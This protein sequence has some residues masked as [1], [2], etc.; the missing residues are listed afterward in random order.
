MTSPTK[1]A[2]V[3][4]SSSDDPM[5]STRIAALNMF[6]YLRAAGFEP[7]VV[8]EPQHGLETPDLSGLAPVIS[9]R[10]FQFVF[11]Q[12]VHG[13]SVLACVQ[14][15]REL[16]VKTV[17]SV[18]DI[19]DAE[20]ARACDITLT[21][22][23]FLK[24]QYPVE[25][26]DKIVTIHDG[27][28]RPEFSKED[29]GTHRGSRWRPIRAVLVTSMKLDQ[30]PVLK[31]IPPWLH[32]HIV[33]RY[34]PGHALGARLRGAYDGF[35][36]Q[37]GWRERWR[38]LRFLCSRRIKRQAWDPVGV[39]DALQEADIGIIPIDI[40]VDHKPHDRRYLKSE[41]RLTLKMAVGL[42]VVASPLPA[43][44][45]V[46]QQGRNGFLA[47]TK[48]EWLLCL[49]K[50]RDPA[51]RREIGEQARATALASYSID[52]QAQRLIKA[53][54][55]LIRPYQ[56]DAARLAEHGDGRARSYEVPP[57]G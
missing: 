10:G 16:G 1:I 42:P 38:F 54:R 57:L 32:I 35:R 41:N 51:L 29:W 9:S 7:E 56:A 4:L 28:E 6:P 43:Y 44:H 5:P 23:D 22:T 36:R 8:F 13:S 17:Y 37:R 48:D 21:V 19:V 25:L 11:F 27:V 55:S 50:L 2:F 14:E 40:D 47:G 46:V 26:Q 53:L 31:Q 52:L 18:C 3:L 34:A 20:M 15:L 39:Y 30:L 24:S 12:K 49:E 45:S 33:G